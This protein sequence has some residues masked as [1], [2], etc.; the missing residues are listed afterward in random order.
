MV[1]CDGERLDRFG[2]PGRVL[3]SDRLSDLLSSIT[4]TVLPPSLGFFYK[5]RLLLLRF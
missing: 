5:V 2:K 3:I 4:D 1:Y